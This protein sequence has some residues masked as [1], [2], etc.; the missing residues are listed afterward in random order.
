MKTKMG[1]GLVV[2]TA[3]LFS[4]CPELPAVP[5]PAVGGTLPD[6]ELPGPKDRDRKSVV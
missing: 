5:P 4:L 2:L 6:V 3:L 1:I